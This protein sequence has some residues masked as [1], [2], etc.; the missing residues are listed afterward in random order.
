MSEME[1]MELIPVESLRKLN[2]SADL[3]HGEVK[4]AV[5]GLLENPVFR[6]KVVDVVNKKVNLPLIN[7]SME[8][9]LFE[10]AYDM[11]VSAIIAAVD[12]VD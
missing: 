8:A 12:L 6:G 2:V 10:Q 9:R 4:K 3:F 7:E 1:K 5:K 11:V